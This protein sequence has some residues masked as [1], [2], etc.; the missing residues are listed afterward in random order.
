MTWAP[1]AVVIGAVVLL[2]LVINALFPAHKSI[3]IEPSERALADEVKKAQ[4]EAAE[5]SRKEADAVQT[6]TQ[7][8]RIDRARELANKGKK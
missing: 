3:T 5:K 1:V 2:A 8:E 4:D 7:L 6:M